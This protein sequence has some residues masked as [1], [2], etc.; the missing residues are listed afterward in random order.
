MRSPCRGATI[1]H[2]GSR[3]PCGCVRLIGSARASSFALLVPV[4]GVLSAVLVL[5][6]PLRLSLVTGGAIVLVGLWLAESGS[7]K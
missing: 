2:G 1:E 7:K 4:F 3:R 6:E 5:N